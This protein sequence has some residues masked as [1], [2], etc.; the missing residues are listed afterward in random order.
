VSRRLLGLCGVS[1]VLGATIWAATGGPAAPVVTLVVI[2]T[3]LAAAD[4]VVW[5]AEGGPDG[6][7]DSDLAVPDGRRLSPP[8]WG[9]TVG[10][11]AGL[12]VCA[13]LLAG[14]LWAAAAAALVLVLAGAGLLRPP[15]ER[16][17]PAYVASTARRLRSFAHAH[18]VSPGEPV[19]GYITPVGESGVRMFVVAP[20]GRWA[21]AMASAAEAVQIA[22]LARVDLSDPTDPA[23]GRRVR[24]DDDFWTA[25]ARSW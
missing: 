21:D 5:N 6:S 19:G 18:G 20:D 3:V 9:L 8:P 1:V 2:G 11:A 10:A 12:G 13:A 16:E 25:M 7:G 24:V 4:A 15:P 17:L 14:A 22:Q 23:T